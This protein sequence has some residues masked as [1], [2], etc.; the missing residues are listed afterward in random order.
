MTNK[1]QV[2]CR[3][4]RWVGRVA[5]ALPS[6]RRKRV[7]MNGW[8][9]LFREGPHFFE[10][11]R[12]LCGFFNVRKRFKAETEPN[13]EDA[14][15]KCWRQSQVRSGSRAAALQALQIPRQETL[16]QGWNQGV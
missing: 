12:S 7:T 11:G 5:V 9:T 6:K 8:K 2:A 10:G 3:C 15:E 4:Q 14:C 13:R 16:A 1:R